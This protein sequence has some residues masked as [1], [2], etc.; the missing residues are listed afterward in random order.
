[1][2]LEHG[3][4]LLVKPAAR[5]PVR[6]M[7][8]EHLVPGWGSKVAHPYNLPIET[9][10]R[11]EAE[12]LHGSRFLVAVLHREYDY[13][14]LYEELFLDAGFVDASEAVEHAQRV[15]EDHCRA[16]QAKHPLWRSLPIPSH[17][18]PANNAPEA[19]PLRL[20]PQ[21]FGDGTG[22]NSREI[23]VA[24]LPVEPDQP[25]S[26]GLFLMLDKELE[27]HAYF[28]QVGENRD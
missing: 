3:D 28:R 11:T 4:S 14:G 2:D 20:T 26:A 5:E 18:W 1:M 19:N 22:F 23:H 12:R 13:D 21:K 15:R 24:V 6:M 17:Q 9:G 8:F 27:L 25:L 7:D 10:L 16:L